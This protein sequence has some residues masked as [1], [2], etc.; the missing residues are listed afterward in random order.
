MGYHFDLRPE[1]RDAEN[2]EFMIDYDYLSEMIEDEIKVY[3]GYG[4]FEHDR[5]TLEIEIEKEAQLEAFLKTLKFM[6]FPSPVCYEETEDST[7]YPV[8]TV[9]SMK[10]NKAIVDLEFKQYLGKYEQAVNFKVEV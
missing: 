6:E 1:D 7:F 3:G 5:I 8:F 10:G 2:D 4:E 9:T